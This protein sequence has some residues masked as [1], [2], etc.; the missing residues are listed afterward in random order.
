L[1]EKVCIISVALYVLVGLL[2]GSVL[3]WNLR[4]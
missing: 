4:S 3:V 2:H 1:N